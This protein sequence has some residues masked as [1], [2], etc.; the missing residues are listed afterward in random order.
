MAFA[1]TD[2]TKLVSLGNKRMTIGS[3][4]QAS[5]D[6]GGAFVTGLHTVEYFHCTGLVSA[7]VSG[8]TV[9]AT[10]GNPGGDQ[11]GYWQAIGY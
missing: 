2:D 8:G 4:T 9:T 3:F 10:T 7:S 6:T 11:A 1:Q 5:G